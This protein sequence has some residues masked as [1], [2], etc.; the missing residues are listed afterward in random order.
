MADESGLSRAKDEEI[1]SL[2]FFDRLSRD[3]SLRVPTEAVSVNEEG[4]MSGGFGRF[5]V[6]LSAWAVRMPECSE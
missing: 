1:S 3:S 6:D 5:I 4:A 2:V